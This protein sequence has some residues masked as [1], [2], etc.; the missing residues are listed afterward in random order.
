MREVLTACSPHHLWVGIGLCEAAGLCSGG[1]EELGL[2]EL[3]S[4]IWVLTEAEDTVDVSEEL[5]LGLA[6]PRGK[7]ER[8]EES[9]GW[10]PRGP[11]SQSALGLL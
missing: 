2:L 11:E 8:G 4:G 5:R 3:G 6:L 1:W 10:V 9:S 7:G